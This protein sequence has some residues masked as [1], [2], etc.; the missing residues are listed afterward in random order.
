MHVKRSLAAVLLATPVLLLSAPLAPAQSTRPTTRPTEVEAGLLALWPKDSLGMVIVKD[1]EQLAGRAERF[2]R[3]VAG[4]SMPQEFN[5]LRMITRNAGGG[6]GATFRTDGSF[7]ILMLDPAEVTADLAR[8]LGDHERPAEI[9]LGPL[10]LP[11]VFLLPGK[12]PQA[13]FPEVRLERDGRLFKVGGGSAWMAELDGYVALTARK[14]AAAA[15]TRDFAVHKPSSTHRTMLAECDALL[16]V[17]RDRILELRG[18]RLVEWARH[19]VFRGQV[20]RGIGQVALPGAYFYLTRHRALTGAEAL[21]VGLRFDEEA[22]QVE[23]RWSFDPK[24]LT[25]KAMALLPDQPGPLMTRVPTDLP[26]IFAYGATKRF[27]TPMKLKKA[28]YEGLL[29]HEVLER[30]PADVKADALE[31]VMGL[32]EEVTGVQHY[33]GPGKKSG[34]A[35]GAVSVV[36]CRSPKRMLRLVR[37]VPEVGLKILGETK[38]GLPLRGWSARYLAKAQQFGDRAADAILL[39]HP[40]MVD[41]DE[42]HR[43]QIRSLIGH[44][45][46]RAL[47]CQVDEK[48]LVMTFGGGRDLMAAAI[49]AATGE[50]KLAGVPAIRRQLA[51]LPGRRCAVGAVSPVN[52]YNAYAATIKRLWGDMGRRFG[53]GDPP[54]PRSEVPIVFCL[55]VEGSDLSLTFRVPAEPLG[56]ILR[57]T[58]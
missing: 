22:V 42:D 27:A 56:E 57:A 52:G 36:E 55:S 54:G 11:F 53:D 8:P 20:A 3:L 25:A 50:K 16:W 26:Y 49:E 7:G 43:E 14:E 29:A 32:Q 18:S 30:V 51:A 47:I 44:D 9:D 4:E 13:M 40:D 38:V 37:R 12:D 33:F 31:I 1:V 2:A 24:S 48:T 15:M 6:L 28:Q 17:N 34:G 39:E 21:A 35:L 10:D 41:M 45:K 19:H 5:L 23:A 46:P 58:R